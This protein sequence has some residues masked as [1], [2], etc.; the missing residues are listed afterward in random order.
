VIRKSVTTKWKKASTLKAIISK[1]KLAPFL[2][3]GPSIA[4]SVDTE[5]DTQV[6]HGNAVRRHRDGK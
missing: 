2:P 6:K 1:K 3:P 4:L 5:K